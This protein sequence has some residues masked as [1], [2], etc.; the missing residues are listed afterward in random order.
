MNQLRN[1]TGTHDLNPSDIALREYI[2]GVAK[3]CFINYGGQ[4]IDTPV[5]ELY[6]NVRDLYGEEF[7]KLVYKFKDEHDDLILRYDLTVPFA[8]FV[9]M[10][11]LRLFRRFQIGTVY[12][13]DDPQISKGRYRA[14]LQ[15]DFDIAGSDLGSGVFDMEV[16]QLA[17]DLLSK[18]LGDH[19]MIRLNHKDLISQYLQKLNVPVDNL[20]TV[21]SSIDKLDKKNLE[22]V[23]TELLQKGISGEIVEDISNLIKELTIKRTS[24]QTL[25]YLIQNNLIEGNTYDQFSI[26]LDKLNYTGICDKIVFDPLLA[27]GLD[28]Y[29]GII[30]EA[31]YLDKDI[32]GTS[33]CAGG[34]Y[35]NLIGKFSNH[36]QIPAVGISLGIERIATILENTKF[37][38]PKNNIDVYVASIGEGMLNERIKLCSL[39]RKQNISTMMSYLGNPKMRT[40]FDDVFNYDAKY[41]VIIGQEEMKS[42]VIKIKTIATKVE[43]TFNLNDGVNKLKGLIS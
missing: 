5:M 6:D 41:M 33:I 14:F 25:D 30:F 16:L 18:L 9:G 4:Q 26:L 35:D 3:Q 7:H 34:R 24:K 17:E 11:G 27:R 21:C 43:E 15:A 37:S 42:E 29:S 31:Y 36:G 32:M 10:N 40:Q 28:Y 12:R 23:C 8:R 39:L 13:C 22:E 2:I 20:S 1:P 19:F 38:I